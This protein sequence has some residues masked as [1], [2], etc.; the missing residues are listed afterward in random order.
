VALTIS[1]EWRVLSHNGLLESLGDEGP[2]YNPER[3]N[4]SD[5]NTE[6]PFPTREAAI[7]RLEAW[8]KKY[9][10]HN[11]DYVL[12]EIFNTRS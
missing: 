3:L 11:V 4:E 7:A 9:P 12:V 10:H 6:F 2:S 1:F 5:E 8:G